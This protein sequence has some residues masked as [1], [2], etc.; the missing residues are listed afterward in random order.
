MVL[1]LKLYLIINMLIQKQDVEKYIHYKNM[2]TLIDESPKLDGVQAHV[3]KERRRKTFPLLNN[4][5]NIKY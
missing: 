2:R 3:G 1:K 4:P 5:T